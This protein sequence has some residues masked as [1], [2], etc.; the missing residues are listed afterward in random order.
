MKLA[1][2]RFADNGN[3]TLG[4]LYIDGIFECFTVEDEER[5][6]KKKGETRVPNGTYDVKLRNSG[7]YHQKYSSRY[8]SMHKGMLCIHNK[9]DW[10]LQNDG[11]VF[12]YILIHTGNTE[13]HTAGC[14]LVNDAVSGKTFTGSSSRDAYLDFYPKVVKEL[15]NGCEVTIEYTDIETGK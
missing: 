7:G 10:I 3:T 8:G 11:M 15:N 1:V 14:L 4:I 2:K 6:T 12:Q 13:K 9:A 5:E